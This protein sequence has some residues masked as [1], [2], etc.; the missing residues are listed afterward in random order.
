MESAPVTGLFAAVDM[1]LVEQ[2]VSV[3]VTMVMLILIAPGQLT[4]H[5][6]VIAANGGMEP[7]TAIVD[8]TIQIAMS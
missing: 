4:V 5:G 3:I 7:V 1:A 8:T 2:T 6:L